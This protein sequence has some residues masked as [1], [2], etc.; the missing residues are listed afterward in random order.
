MYLELKQLIHSKMFFTKISV[1]LFFI[2]FLCPI[3]VMSSGWS[4]R[5]NIG[6]NNN[7]PSTPVL[8]QH[9][10]HSP[11]SINGNE[12]FKT[13]IEE[14]NWTG[15]GTPSAPFIIDGLNITGYPTRR[16]IEISNTDVYFQIRNCVLNGGYYGIYFQN[17][18]NGYILSNI[19]INHGFGI[20]ISYS[21]NIGMSNN[22]IANINGRGIVLRFCVNTHLSSNIIANN[23]EMGI[24]ILQSRGIS[25]S[26][27]F[28]SNNYWGIDL[29]GI[30]CLL[31]GNTI[32]NNNELGIYLDGSGYGIL[33]GNMIINNSGSGI[34]L[35]SSRNILSGNYFANNSDYGVELTHRSNNNK[36]QANMFLGNNRGGSQTADQGSNNHFSDNFWDDWI[37]PDANMDGIVDQPYP[38]PGIETNSDL[39]PLVTPYHL[40]PAVI[41]SPSGGPIFSGNITLQW[42]PATDLNSHPITYLVSYSTDKGISWI[43][44][45]ANLS[46]TSYIWD[47]TTVGNGTQYLIRVN[48]SCTQGFWYATTS[49]AIFIFENGDPTS[50]ILSPHSSIQPTPDNG[51]INTTTKAMIS[52]CSSSSG[53]HFISPGFP[54]L[55]QFFLQIFEMGVI[56]LFVV[57]LVNVI[58]RRKG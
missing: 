44:L 1:I 10:I 22:T 35:Q 15:E 49:G 6:K 42:T 37:T 9:V 19:V 14:E 25:L 48:A 7:Q 5:I 51:F 31:T 36:I 30:Y 34:Y 3:N 58:R 26:N 28:V 39:S 29:V 50:N 43:I 8:I 41:I 11:L 47:S 33:S 56:T 32:S 27:N 23:T 16:L 4:S 53:S 38:I 13:L 17:V 46:T 55:L 12:E 57:T 20:F 18:T 40:L 24:Q 54:S 2:S 45:I 21:E 52:S